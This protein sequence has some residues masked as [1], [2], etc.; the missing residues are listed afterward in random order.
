M[1][2]IS[3]QTPTPEPNDAKSYVL[4][5]LVTHYP[6]LFSVDELFREYV[7]QDDPEMARMYVEEALISLVSYGL[8]HRAGE[9]AF[10]SRA[11]VQGRA[12][13]M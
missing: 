2:P 4:D 10:A 8:V 6:A 11:A 3:M 9:F 12:L 5:F 7:G 1:I 13:A